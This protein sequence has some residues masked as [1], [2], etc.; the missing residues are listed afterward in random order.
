MGD[1]RKLRKKYATPMH[2]WEGS[3][4]KEEKTLIKEYGLKNK[5]EI[6]KIDSILKNFSSQAKRLTALE[7]PQAKKEQKQL[8]TR[9]QK[10]GLLS[11]EADLDS[12][13]NLTLRDIMSRRLQTVV[14]NIG[15][16]RS[17]K[18]ARQM[19]THRHVTIGG[20]TVTSPNYLVTVKEESTIN[21]SLRSNFKDEEH[22]ERV[23]KKVEE[24]M[25]EASEKAEKISK[26]KEEKKDKKKLEKNEVKVEK[27]E[28]KLEKNVEEEKNTEKEEKEESKEDKKP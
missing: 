26:E 9:I 6:W 27:K 12:V 22:P 17:P 1:P 19:I 10:Y 18:Q 4:I 15:L 5:K 11:S 28:A 25:E 13:L 21:F 3:R 8:L 24:K 2:P 14:Y 23:V 16:A 7:G 20:K